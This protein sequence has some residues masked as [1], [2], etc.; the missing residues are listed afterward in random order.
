M[1]KAQ[2]LKKVY[3]VDELNLTVISNFSIS[4]YTGKQNSEFGSKLVDSFTWMS[5]TYSF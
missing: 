5:L 4:K 3:K 2:N 1:I